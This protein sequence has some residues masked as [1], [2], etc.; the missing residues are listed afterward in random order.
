MV[1]LMTLA[2]CSASACFSG[3]RGVVGMMDSGSGS[4]VSLVLTDLP[5]VYKKSTNFQDAHFAHARLGW[6]S[7]RAEPQGL[8]SNSG[9][10]GTACKSK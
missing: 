8:K 1:E 7:C 2:R 5:L 9:L 3:D 4:G 10:C 6:V